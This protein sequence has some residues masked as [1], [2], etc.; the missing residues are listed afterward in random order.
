ME[1]LER[2]Q[3]FLTRA[4]NKLEEARRQLEHLNYAESVSAAQE[5]AEF[6]VKAMFLACG[7]PF[8][9]SHEVKELRF[10]ELLKRIPD[11]VAQV[12]NLP[13]VFLLARFWAE[14]YL[15]AKYGYEE[16][17]VGPDKLFKSEEAKLAVDHARECY[18]ASSFLFQ[19]VRWPRQG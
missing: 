12:Y 8:P 7:A 18:D 14:F 4:R 9:K 10:A 11:E 1:N 5:S 19:K 3:S 2:A 13:R 16:M 15:V 17:N 6:S